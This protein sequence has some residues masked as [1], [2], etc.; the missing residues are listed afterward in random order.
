MNYI[1]K[2]CFGMREKGCVVLKRTFCRDN[3]C[4]FYKPRQQ[5]EKEREKYAA[6]EYAYKGI[7]GRKIKSIELL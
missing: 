6:H 5:Y 7:R 4:P 3:H 1:K 2:D